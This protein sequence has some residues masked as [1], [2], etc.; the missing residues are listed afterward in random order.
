MDFVNDQVIGGDLDIVVPDRSVAGGPSSVMGVA[1]RGTGE[2]RAQARPRQGAQGLVVATEELVPAGPREGLEEPELWDIMDT[3]RSVAGLIPNTY[4]K[5]PESHDA[6][7]VSA[8]AKDGLAKA[9]ARLDCLEGVVPVGDME[10][11]VCLLFDKE[12]GVEAL[13]HRTL[14]DNIAFWHKSGASQFALSVIENGYIPKLAEEVKFYQ[15]RN[16]KSYKEHRLWAN[17]DVQKLLVGK[18]VEKVNKEEL[19]CINPLSMATNSKLKK[20]LC[21]DLSR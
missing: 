12:I 4:F 2:H 20:R 9:E 21:M 13:V 7:E 6:L 18:I 1:G 17:E 3:A 16:N 19:V 11:D 14:K 8:E 15:E 10:E 5:V